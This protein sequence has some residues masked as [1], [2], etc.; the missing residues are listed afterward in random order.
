MIGE[1]TPIQNFSMIRQILKDSIGNQ[2]M[3]TDLSIT[4]GLNTQ[5]LVK[6]DG[7][8]QCGSNHL[9]QISISSKPVF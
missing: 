2:S 3:V 5:P 7:I 1:C 8:T 4:C 9:L 6:L